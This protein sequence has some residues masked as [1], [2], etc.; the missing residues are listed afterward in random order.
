[1]QVRLRLGRYEEAKRA[2]GEYR[3][4]FGAENY[5]CEVMDH[6]LSIEKR[7]SKDLLRL[8]KELD[9]PLV[10]TNDLHYTNESDGEAHEALLAIQSGSKLIEPTYDQGGSRFA[11]AAPATT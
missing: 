9:I 3:E 10:A 1:M 5:F 8:S 11:S 2:A 4:I 7:V 6:G